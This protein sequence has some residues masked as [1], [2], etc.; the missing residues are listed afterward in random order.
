MTFIPPDIPDPHELERKRNEK[1]FRRQYRPEIRLVK[2]I[3]VD[4]CRTILTPG[5]KR[6]RA[7]T[8]QWLLDPDEPRGGKWTCEFLRAFG[9]AQVGGYPTNWEILTQGVQK[10]LGAG[11]LFPAPNLVPKAQYGLIT[12]I[13]QGC[14]RPFV[15]SK[16]KHRVYCGTVCGARAGGLARGKLRAVLVAGV[17]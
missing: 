10:A 5:N 14:G 13:C 16:Y 6:D 2:A 3:L 8:L 9:I 15:H 12:G 17:A 11:L 4:A 1:A 7:L